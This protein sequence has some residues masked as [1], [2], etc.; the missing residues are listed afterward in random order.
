MLGTVAT[1][2]RL[3][4][5]LFE[6]RETIKINFKCQE[7]TS[8]PKGRKYHSFSLNLI[9]F[10]ERRI[11]RTIRDTN[12]PSSL[13]KLAEINDKQDMINQALSPDKSRIQMQKR[14]KK[15]Y[16]PNKRFV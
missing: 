14:A 12:G 16:T 9:S 2:E 15:E 13:R 3:V 10:L 7:I 8:N 4:K 11:T 6:N 1:K 5:Y